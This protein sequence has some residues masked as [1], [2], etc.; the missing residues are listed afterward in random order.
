MTKESKPDL[1][2][3]VFRVNEEHYALPVSNIGSIERMQ[4]ITRVPRANTF[5]KGV[6]NLRGIVT[7]VIDLSKKFGREEIKVTEEAR[8]IIV[9]SGKKKV[10]FVVEEVYDVLDIPKK[11]INPE[12][13]TAGMEFA[14]YISDVVKNREKLLILLDLDQLLADKESS[15]LPK[16][17]G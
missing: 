6:I 14:P 8:I 12:S 16:K 13:K 5:V 7:P 17:R 10:G 9:S 11:G 2:V 1:K 4:H 15:V 3:L